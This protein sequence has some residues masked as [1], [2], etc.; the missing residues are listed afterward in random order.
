MC[1]LRDFTAANDSDI[2]HLIVGHPVYARE[3]YFR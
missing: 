1:D 2:E 3:M